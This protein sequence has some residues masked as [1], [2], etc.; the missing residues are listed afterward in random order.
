VL[1][2]GEAGM[3]KSHLLCDITLNRLKNHLP[4]LF[5]LGQHYQGANPLNT[6]QESLGL[7]DISHHEFLGA[8]DAAGEAKATNTLI[9]IDAI[10]EGINRDEWVHFLGAFLS[11]ILNFPN[12]SVVLSCRSTYVDYLIQ[13]D[14]IGNPLVEVVHRGFS[15][16]EH[17]AASKY[18]S[19]QGISKPS[20]PI[21]APE[22]TNPLFLKTC[23]KALKDS[24]QSSFPKG[25]QGI[26]KLFNFYIDSMEKIV[27]KKKH[28]RPREH[29]IKNV[30]ENFTKA[31]YPDYLFGLPLKT[32][33]VLINNLDPKPNN[34]DDLF[35]ILIQEGVLSEDLVFDH[36]TEKSS[37]V[38]RF[39]YE[40]F[41][42]HF[43]A[44]HI[45]SAI[46]TDSVN[47]VFKACGSL[48][49]LFN[50][51]NYFANSGIL[52]ALSILIAERFQREMI[53]LVPK[54]ISDKTWLFDTLFTKTLLWR[55][56][57]SFT[58]RTLKLLN[59]VS[60]YGFH[61]PSL[62]ILIALS[63]EPLHP[64]NAELL[65]RN[66]FKMSMPDRDQF[67]STHIA[68]SDY[69][70]E[71]NEEESVLRSLIE[72]AHSGV[73]DQV[74][75]ERVHLC[76]IVLIWTTSTPNRRVRD[77]ATKSII[78]ILSLYPEELL[79]ILEKF[80]E[81]DDL[82][83]LERLYAVAYGVLSNI[84]DEQ[85]IK[86]IADFVFNTIFSAGRPIPHILLRDYAT[87]VME[88]AL[89]RGLVGSIIDPDRFRPPF[90]S[91]WPLF[92][93]TNEELDDLMGDKYASSIRSSIMGFPGDF[94]NYS[95]S[96]IHNWSPTPIHK[97]KPQTAYEHQCEFAENLQGELKTQFL[98]HIEEQK[99]IDEKPFDETILCKRIEIE[100]VS[101]ETEKQ[102]TKYELLNDKIESTLSPKQKEQ[103]RWVMGLGRSN[104]IGAFSRK[105]AHRWVCKR[106]I[107][108]GWTK[109]LFEEFERCHTSRDAGRSQ[110]KIE[111]IGKKYQWIAFF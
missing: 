14:L 44:D 58:R 16:F 46:S 111:R 53:D 51:D 38:V 93:P 75:P 54:N 64:W 17:R 105:K 84:D 101:P 45:A 25:L 48:G 63:T 35:D 56:G 66:L 94:G 92:D 81:V 12:L 42:D 108:L 28:Y 89:E 74:E 47:N 70:E 50:N 72:W 73:M 91:K 21:T 10:N 78:R 82:Y 110:S 18:L 100:I 102:P 34:G 61:S 39:T 13:E 80:C 77:Q 95:M 1:L 5:V 104:S 68:V 3:G 99:I 86:G 60:G 43:V 15:G 40:R 23:C 65:H 36:N 20:T 90:S 24:E 55:T 96:C 62:E 27:A 4:T 83:I 97:G 11:D 109:E 57:Q 67:W 88:L 8:L 2:V 98:A 87:G 49:L 29:V 85:V 106:T 52:S 30:L 32:A 59:Q 22:F 19:A 6:L 107:E 31:L 9:V 33:R 69:D 76:A 7:N 41:S 103:F 71:E 26:T 37:P 79:P